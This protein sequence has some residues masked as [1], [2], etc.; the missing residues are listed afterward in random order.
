MVSSNKTIFLNTPTLF[1]ATIGATDLTS[2]ELE[3]LETQTS[4]EACRNAIYKQI[5]ELAMH[6]H[7]EAK[8]S[9]LTKLF[10]APIARLCACLIALTNTVFSGLLMH[11]HFIR[12]PVHCCVEYCCPLSSTKRVP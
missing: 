12:L 7:V 8:L 11:M 1:A 10:S 5:G 9:L 6:V 4:M 2:G 3:G